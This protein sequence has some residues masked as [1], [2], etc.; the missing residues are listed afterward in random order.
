MKKKKERRLYIQA[1]VAL[2]WLHVYVY[3]SPP[4]K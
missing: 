3:E 4:K 1:A 2:T